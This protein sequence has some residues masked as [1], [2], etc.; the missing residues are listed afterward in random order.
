MIPT[1]TG[2]TER[3]FAVELLLQ[4]AERFVHRFTFLQTDFGHNKITSFLFRVREFENT[5]LI[6]DVKTICKFMNKRDL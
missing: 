4:A 2:L 5:N 3:S 6:S 1:Q